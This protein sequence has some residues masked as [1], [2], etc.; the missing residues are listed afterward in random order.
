[1]KKR[2][3]LRLQ[4]KIIFLIY[5]KRFKFFQFVQNSGPFWAV[6]HSLESLI[7][8]FQTIWGIG[9]NVF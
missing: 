4:K 9:F 6:T 5:K 1:M 7:Q 2:F 3:F 8:P